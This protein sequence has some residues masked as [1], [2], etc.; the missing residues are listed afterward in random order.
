MEQR[1]VTPALHPLNTLRNTV[2]FFSKMSWI[3]VG[4]VPVCYVT[5][6]DVVTHDSHIMGPV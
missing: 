6:L 2:L 4:L 1:W 3:Q 5:F